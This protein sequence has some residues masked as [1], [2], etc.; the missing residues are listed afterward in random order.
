MKGRSGEKVGRFHTPER[1]GVEEEG[2][3]CRMTG[4]AKTSE[5]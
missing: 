4:A 3:G 2:I 5:D 1:G